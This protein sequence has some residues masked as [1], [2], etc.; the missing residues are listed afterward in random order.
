MWKIEIDKFYY[1]DNIIMEKYTLEAD[2]NINVN[3][4][5]VNQPLIETIDQYFFN[6]YIFNDTCS[7]NNISDQ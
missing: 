5:F 6:Q 3:G 7:V 1:D 2:L 4:I